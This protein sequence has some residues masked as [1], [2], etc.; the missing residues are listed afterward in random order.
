MLRV[1]RV[2][3]AHFTDHVLDGARTAGVETSD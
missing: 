3:G 1:D 2:D